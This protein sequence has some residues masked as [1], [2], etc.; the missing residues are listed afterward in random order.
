MYKE[1][2]IL[3]FKECFA[4]EKTHGT[5]SHVSWD[6]KEL[7][8]FSGGASHERFVSLFNQDIL[9]QKFVDMGLPIEKTITIFGEAYGGKEQGMSATYGKELKFVAFD[10]QIGECWLDV[11]KAEEICKNLGLEF[12]HYVKISTDLKELDAQRDA[13][14]VQAIRNGVGPGKMR[15]GIVIRPLIEL[16]KNNGARIICKHKRD[17]FRETKSPRP[18]IDPEKLKVLAEAEQIADEYVTLTRLQHVLQKIPDHSIEKMGIII[19]AMVEDVTREAKGEIVESDAAKKAIG[20]KTALMY[21]NFLNRKLNE[22]I[23]S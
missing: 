12:V 14:S 6:G 13:D 9:K 5:S 1:Q 18:I 8:F 7:K 22:S 21:K 11:P 17:E 15:E 16:T 2:D 4:L 3:L 19:R 10:V 23:M 20:K